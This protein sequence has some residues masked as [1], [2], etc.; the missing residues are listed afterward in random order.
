MDF[1]FRSSIMTAHKATYNNLITPSVTYHDHGVKVA[2][3]LIY[4]PIYFNHID[5]C[6]WRI[7]VRQFI[8]WIYFQQAIGIK[9]LSNKAS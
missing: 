5:I 2:I 4:D 7:K 6:T 9:I 3:L 1:I 8:A